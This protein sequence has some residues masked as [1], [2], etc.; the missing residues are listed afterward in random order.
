MNFFFDRPGVTRIVGLEQNPKS[1]TKFQEATKLYPLA[2]GTEP[3]R[4]PA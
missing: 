4:F 3:K 1:C 2:Q